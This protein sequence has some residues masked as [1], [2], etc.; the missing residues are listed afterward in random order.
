MSILFLFLLILLKSC[1]SFY[2]IDPDEYRN[3]IEL[4][5]SKGYP[6]E[7]HPVQTKDGYILKMHRIP[8]SHR[9]STRSHFKKDIKPVVFLQH[10]LLDVNF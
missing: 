5:T 4:I 9:I 8:T 10:G 6:A 3:T 1:N 2:S 7:E